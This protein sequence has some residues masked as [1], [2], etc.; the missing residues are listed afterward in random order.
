MLWESGAEISYSSFYRPSESPLTRVSIRGN[1]YY[2]RRYDPKLI[3]TFRSHPALE[4]PPDFQQHLMSVYADEPPA[5]EAELECQMAFHRRYFYAGVGP[6]APGMTE[7]V[8]A[9][10]AWLAKQNASRTHIVPL[11]LTGRSPESYGYRR[12][13]P[14][15]FAPSAVGT[16]AARDSDAGVIEWK[17]HCSPKTDW[18]VSGEVGAQRAVF[19]HEGLLVNTFD[20]NHEDAV[21]CEIATEP[22]VVDA[23]LVT[24]FVG[25]GKRP[26]KVYVALE[27]DGTPVRKATGCTTE[28]MTRRYWDTSDLRGKTAR[29]VIRDKESSG[30]GHILVDGIEM[31][32][33][34]GAEK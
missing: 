32:Q 15:D 18:L 6:D 14:L 27:I 13:A 16:S 23:D 20:A 28:I 1:P 3:E 9:G 8:A 29:I 33:K 12:L 34:I 11:V 25:G 7:L 17:A 19:G 5:S 30:W 26:A 24:L 22:F 10:T 2:L 31:W 4:P 21:I